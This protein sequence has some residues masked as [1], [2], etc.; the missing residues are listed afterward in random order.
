MV[1]RIPKIE[2]HII[3]ST[4]GDDGFK[5]FLVQKSEQPTKDFD[6]GVEEIV[7]EFTKYKPVVVRDGKTLFRQQGL[8]TPDVDD[9]LT[10][11]D[12]REDKFRRFLRAFPNKTS[13]NVLISSKQ[14][15]KVGFLKVGIRRSISGIHSIYIRHRKPGTNRGIDRLLE[16][17]L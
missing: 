8:V 1:P 15:K 10:R 6:H 2:Q 9:I 5:G 13:L 7:E 16:Y 17:T 14:S 12:K 11:K 4:F 3:G